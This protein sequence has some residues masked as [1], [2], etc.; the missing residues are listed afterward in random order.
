M[1]NKAPKPG[2]YN[3]V[4][5]DEY[6]QWEAV[7]NSILWTL[8]THSPLHAKT[9]MDSPPEPTEAFIIGR[10][11]HTLVLEPR[12]FNK[13]YAVTPVC[14]RRTKDGKAI[15]KA[16]QDNLNG[17]EILT[18]DQFEMIDVMA[19]SI[20]R[21]IIHR[22]IE[23]GEAEVCIV[24]IDK[25]TGL[26]CKARIDYVHRKRSILIDL[27]STRDASPNDFSKSIYNYGYYQQS[28][29]YSDGWSVLTGDPTAFVFLPVEKKPP[30]EPAAYEMREQVIYAGRQSYRQALDTFAECKKKDEWPGYA[31]EVVMLSLP[32]WA[33]NKE[34][35]GNYQIFE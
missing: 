18:K 21:Q 31:N 24:W 26:I 19:D 13:F 5:F 33:L 15:Y 29:F 9:Y 27:K 14:D 17:Q 3:G 30:Y 7:N 2:I 35:I 1:K 11:L 8:K 32:Q 23:R 10:A 12:K 34:G 16:F 4:P 28:A 25:K 22:L 6:E 20:K